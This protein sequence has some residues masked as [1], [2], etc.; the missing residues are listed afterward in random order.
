MRFVHVQF[1]VIL[2][3]VGAMAG[4]YLIFDQD[5]TWNNNTG[6]AHTQFPSPLNWRDGTLYHRI[7]VKSKPSDRKV[8]IELCVW[9]GGETCSGCHPYFTEVGTYYK[10]DTAGVWWT[11]SGSPISGWD[12]HGNRAHILANEKCE[13]WIATCGN[14]WCDG[15]GAAADLPV[16]VHIT[17]YYVDP[18][19]EFDCP[20]DWVDSE[21]PG[22]PTTKADGGS[23]RPRSGE[24]GIRVESVSPHGLSLRLPGPGKVSF[25]SSNGVRLATAQAGSSGRVSVGELSIAS[26]VLLVKTEGEHPASV[27]VFVP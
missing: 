22:C 21:L 9:S 27:K 16:T 11:L 1:A 23:R 25:Y 5:I 8:G 13:N 4:Q 26:G 17:E 6:A 20:D 3:A 7:E 12:S 19:E 10:M 18:D 15:P 2:C 24:A 14:P